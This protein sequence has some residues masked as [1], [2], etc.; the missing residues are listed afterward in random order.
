[1]GLLS[2]DIQGD[3]DFI[4]LCSLVRIC[5]ILGFV[6]A[7]CGGITTSTIPETFTEPIQEPSVDV[8][9]PDVITIEYHNLFP[10][11]IE[12]DDGESCFLI[13]SVTEG[14]IHSVLDDGTIEPFIEDEELLSTGG[15][16][17]DHLN[18][19]LLVDNTSHELDHGM[20]A[21][22]DL[23]T[24]ERIFVTDLTSLNPSASHLANDVAVDANG[25]AY[26]TDTFAPVIYRV[27]VDGEAS[28][29]TTD[30]ALK[31]INGI[32]AHPNGYLILGAYQNKL[33]KIRFDDPRVV[34]IELADNIVFDVT[35][36][37]VLH[38]DGT[39]IM[40]T[41]PDSII[42]RLSSDDDW[43][44]AGLVSESGDHIDGWGTTVAIR[45]DD[46]YV[47]HSHLNFFQEN[48]GDKDTYKI[49]RVEFE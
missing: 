33:L 17:I 3:V 40:V 9:P 16:E 11:G 19:R 27:D 12:Y 48:L 31:Y 34:P 15:I 14:T 20:L 46:V 39:L 42:Y 49:V 41:F 2:G 35:D 6:L 24:G 23:K 29:F 36:G 30:I 43:D 37:M 22:Y 38:P 28:I 10:E 47:I 32:L 45:G 8:S 25:I 5:L 1:M 21:A 44:S 26:V 18:N 7:G 13:G 4:W